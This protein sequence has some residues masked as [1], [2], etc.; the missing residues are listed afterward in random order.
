[1]EYIV[2]VFYCLLAGSV[3]PRCIIIGLV[4]LCRAIVWCVTFS[5]RSVLLYCCCMRTGWQRCRIRGHVAF[6]QQHV[7]ELQICVNLKLLRKVSVLCL[8]LWAVFQ[9]F[10]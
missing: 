9:A 5:A 4:T 6:C 3:G 10:L 1:M 7:A 8:A 2:V